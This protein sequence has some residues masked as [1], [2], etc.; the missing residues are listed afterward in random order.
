MDL[1]KSDAIGVMKMELRYMVYTN[2]S[3]LCSIDDSSV[4]ELHVRGHRF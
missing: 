3:M 2:P 1:S 4:V